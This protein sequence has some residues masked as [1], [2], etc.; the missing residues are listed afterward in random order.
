MSKNLEAIFGFI[1]RSDVSFQTLACLIETD[2]TGMRARTKDTN[3][4]EKGELVLGWS[5][6]L[7]RKKRGPGD[8]PS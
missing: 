8:W 6:D 5:K 2:F 7:L 1:K 4:N 3:L